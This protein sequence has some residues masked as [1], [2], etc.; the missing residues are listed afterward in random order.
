MTIHLVIKQAA[1]APSAASSSATSTAAPTTGSTTSTTSTAAP[2]PPPDVSQSPF[3]LGGFGGI[4]GSDF[5]DILT[6]CQSSNQSVQ[7]NIRNAL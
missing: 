2:A 6:K 7:L 1:A 3:G 4:P 5:I